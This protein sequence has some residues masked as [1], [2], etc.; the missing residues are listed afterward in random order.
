MHATSRLSDLVMLISLQHDPVEQK[1]DKLSWAYGL[2]RKRSMNLFP[3]LM[4]RFIADL[5][6]LE[7]SASL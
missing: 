7:G 6:T 5:K 1:S 2:L 4:T 3:D